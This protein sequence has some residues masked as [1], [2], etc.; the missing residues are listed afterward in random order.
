MT[1]TYQK[2]HTTG[3]SMEPHVIPMQSWC[4]KTPCDTTI[5]LHA[6]KGEEG[7]AVGVLEQSEAGVG[8]AG[9]KKLKNPPLGV[10]VLD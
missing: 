9:F 6:G 8:S 1:V 2:V 4:Q 7:K 3:C 10:P 5:P